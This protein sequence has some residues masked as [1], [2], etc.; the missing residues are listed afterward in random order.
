MFS[1]TISQLFHLGERLFTENVSSVREEL[2]ALNREAMEEKDRCMAQ[3]LE[4]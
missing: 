3:E 2:E 1:Q 4:V